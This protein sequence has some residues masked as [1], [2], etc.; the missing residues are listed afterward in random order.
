[1]YFRVS[2]Y[3]HWIVNCPRQGHMK[4]NWRVLIWMNMVAQPFV[5]MRLDE[6]YIIA[7][8]TPYAIKKL[9]IQKEVQFSVN[10]LISLFWRIW[11][12][13]RIFWVH[14]VH[15]IIIDIQKRNTINIIKMCNLRTCWNCENLPSSMN[16]LKFIA[17]ACIYSTVYTCI[18]CIC[19]FQ[20][21][22]ALRLENQNPS[23]IHTTQ[24]GQGSFGVAIKCE[25]PD[26]QVYVKKKVNI[27]I[28][29]IILQIIFCYF[30]F[31]EIPR[32]N[33]FAC[34]S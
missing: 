4:Q 5:D 19:F 25:G 33:L 14:N 23:I 34:I 24:L 11:S 17:D 9:I 30:S 21:F 10:H 16:T 7:V 2:L 15:N 26:S 31:S 27:F 22:E 28:P 3:S 12:Q 29:V 6:L 20:R 8:F 32:K 18:I 13:K 1:M